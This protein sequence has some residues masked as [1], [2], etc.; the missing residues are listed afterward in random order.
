[1]KKSKQAKPLVHT[2]LSDLGCNSVNMLWI[3][4]KLDSSPFYFELLSI[5][6]SDANSGYFCSNECYTK[7]TYQ[8]YH[9]ILDSH[10]PRQ[11]DWGRK[12][13]KE[14][15]RKYE[16]IWNIFPRNTFGL[17]QMI[18]WLR[19][20]WGR[21]RFGTKWKGWYIRLTAKENK[22]LRCAPVVCPMHGGCCYTVTS[23]T[24]NRCRA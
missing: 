23:V 10:I 16:E 11:Y 9:G 14:G 12:R 21:R 1:M 5:V 19:A 24:M 6:T 13:L 7:N 15:G 3:L 22:S 18:G 4:P 17:I 2:H 8:R 20:W